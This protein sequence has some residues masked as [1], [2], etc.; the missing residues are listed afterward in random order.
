MY[1]HVSTVKMFQNRRWLLYWPVVCWVHW[2]YSA[3]LGLH[4]QAIDRSK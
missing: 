2:H 1:V 4:Y 3:I